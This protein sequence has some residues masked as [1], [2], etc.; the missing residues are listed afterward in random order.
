[1]K[2]ILNDVRFAMRALLRTHGFTAVVVLTLALGIGANTAIFSVLRGVLLKPL[3]HRDGDRLVYLRQSADGP[4]RT[5]L[6]FSV[7]EVR[8]LR[9]GVRALAGIAEF[10]SSSAILQRTD[11]PLRLDLGLVTGNYFEVMGLSAILGRVTRP[12]TD[13]GPAAAPVMVLAYETWMTRFGGDSSVVGSQ[14]SVNNKPA[15]IIGVLQPAPFF[16]ER[17]DALMNMVISAHHMDAAMQ[18]G[19]THRMTEVVARLRSAATLEQV[20]AQVNAVYRRVQNE[21]REGYDPAAHYRVAVLPFKEVLGERA[22]LTLWLLMASAAF[23]LIVSVANVANLTLM[24]GVRRE[25]ELVMRAA[26]GA[27]AAT[28]R[29]LLLVENLLLA[30]AGAGVGLLVA[31]NGVELLTVF[32][33]RFSPRANEIRLDATVFGFTLAVAIGIAVLLSLLAPLPNDGGIATRLLAG[34]R[35]VSAGLGKQ[36]LQ[37]SLVIV[38]VAVSVVLLASAGL[39]MRTMFEL[40]K[41]DTGLQAEDVLTMQVILPPSAN[42]DQPSGTDGDAQ[43]IGRMEAM[44]DQIAALPSVS[45]VGI[46]GTLPLRNSDLFNIVQV[47]GRSLAPGEAVQRSEFRMANPDYFRAAGIPLLAGRNFTSTDPNNVIIINKTLADRFFPQENPVGKRIG[48][49]MDWMPDTLKWQTIIGVVG[50]TQDGTLDAEPRAVVFWPILETPTRSAGLV[51]RGDPRVGSLAAQATSIVRRIE[52]GAL[53][54][55]VMTISQFK[56]QSVS[57][58]RLNAVL[59]SSL[60]MLAVIIAM[61]GIAGVL[62]FS[63]NSRTNEIG[64]RMSLGADSGRVQLMI[65]REGGVLVAI[66]LV[67]GIGGAFLATR[68]MRGL[69]FGVEP[70]D[71]STFT[72]VALLMA[73]VGIIACWIPALRAARVDPAVTMRA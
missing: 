10:S 11:G 27:G 5:N 70:N 64:I 34:A 57:P 18:E 67:L 6:T 1:M 42:R 68:I 58:R 53:I 21:F 49:M 41:V 7:P 65:L 8:D 24:R 43:A 52:P 15:T 47:E 29:R 54:E 30:I 45:D 38:Q 25:H 20:R 50:T 23:V 33:S 12:G 39:L 36:R 61:V 35:R 51:I 26:L 4:G 16:P 59:I 63:V 62:A 37:R 60:G 48:W 22:R 46:G 3:P 2:D 73:G 13:D 55:D 40:S 31:S 66:G 19:R 17:V 9:N 56:D 32:A 71:L 14:V 44:R 28:L 72:V 69:L